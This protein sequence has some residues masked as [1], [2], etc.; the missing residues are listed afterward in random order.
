MTTRTAVRSVVSDSPGAPLRL[1]DREVPDPLPGHV[2]VSVEASG[3]CHTDSKVLGGAFG[4]SIFPV[5]PGHEIAGR[6]DAVG[7]GVRPWRVGDRVAI[8][9]YGGHC[10]W[11]DPCRRGSFIHCE[12]TQIPGVAYPGGYAEA[13]LVPA[14]ALARVPDGLTAVEAAPLACAGVTVYNALRRSGLRAGDTV[15]VVGLGGLGHLGVQFAAAMGMRVVTVARGEGKRALAHRLGTHH[16]VDSTAE[17]VPAAL[18]A[19]GRPRAALAT[20]ASSAAMVQ[21]LDGLGDGGELLVI[22]VEPD[23]MPVSPLQLIAP[24]RSVVGHPS[25]IA[26][27]VE[28]TLAFAQLT[29]V[30]AHVEEVPLEDAPAAY[31]RMVAGLA[32]FRMVLV[33]TAR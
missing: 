26:T 1:V 3:V 11:C 19:L 24:S 33:P 6:V 4:P 9:W 25:G 28:D 5:V 10:G 21:A 14:N 29:G 22:G 20:A 8:G 12:N 13:L 27:D 7:E 18:R 32:R 16:Y 2:R 30:R 31:D 17:D 15:A 23:P